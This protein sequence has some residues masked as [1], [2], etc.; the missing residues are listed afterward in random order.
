M[1]NPLDKLKKE[2]SGVDF[3]PLITNLVGTEYIPL[4]LPYTIQTPTRL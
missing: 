1:A 2:S 4:L 3:N